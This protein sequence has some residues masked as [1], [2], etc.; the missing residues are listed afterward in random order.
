MATGGLHS[1]S[2][3]L[4]MSL[5]LIDDSEE[6]TTM[7]RMSAETLKRFCDGFLIDLRNHLQGAVAGGAL[8]DDDLGGDALLEE[9]D[10]GDD[11]DG[12]VTLAKHFQSS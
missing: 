11:A 8:G 7:L 5:T 12:L 2:L 10:V 9:A 3:L 6:S 1:V 4:L